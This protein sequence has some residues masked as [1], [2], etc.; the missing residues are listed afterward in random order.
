VSTRTA[1]IAAVASLVALAAGALAAAFYGMAAGN[2]E[3]G[4]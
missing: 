4:R 1:V 3:D 2:C